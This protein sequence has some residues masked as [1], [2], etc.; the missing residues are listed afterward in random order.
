MPIDNDTLSNMI[1]DPADH[2]AAPADVLASE[3]LSPEQ[4]QAILESWKVDEQEL[5]TATEENMGGSDN[6][7]LADVVAALNELSSRS[8]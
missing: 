6:N 8:D 2:F 7:I 3:Q 5:A 4:K 1:K